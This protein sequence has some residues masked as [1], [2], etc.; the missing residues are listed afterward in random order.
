[1]IPD[2][3]LNPEDS[4]IKK[5]GEAVSSNILMVIR[6]IVQ[7][8]FFPVETYV[9]PPLSVSAYLVEIVLF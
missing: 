5:G 2:T 1:V 9:F 8:V 7:V 3:E 6:S 4:E